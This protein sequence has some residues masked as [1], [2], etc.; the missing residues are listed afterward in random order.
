VPFGWLRSI[1]RAC[2]AWLL[3]RDLLSPSAEQRVGSNGTQQEE[4]LP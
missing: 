4:E 2:T 1:D 3:K